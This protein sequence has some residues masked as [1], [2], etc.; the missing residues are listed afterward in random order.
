MYYFQNKNFQITIGFLLLLTISSLIFSLVL[1]DGHFAYA[2]DD[3]YIHMS[4][5]KH[6]VNQGI[7]SVDG[8]TYASASSSPLWVLVLSPFYLLLGAKLFVY[9]PF[10]LNLLFQILSLQLIF[11]ITKKYTNQ[12]LH[13]LFGIT[14]ILFTPFMALSFGGM[15][16]S[17]QIFLI[18]FCINLF[19][20]YIDAPNLLKSKIYLLIL[21]PFVVFVRYE[22]LA[23]IMGIAI[24]IL[25]YFRDWKLSLGIVA[26]SLIFIVLFGLWSKFIL[27]LGFVPSS[28]MAKSL[29]GDKRELFSLAMS[30]KKNFFHNFQHD[31]IYILFLFNLFILIQSFLLKNRQIYLLSILFIM[32]LFAHLAFA[33][34]GWLY[35]YEAYLIVFGIFNIFIFTYSVYGSN[36]KLLLALFLVLLPFFDRQVFDAPIQAIHGSKNIYEQQIQMANFLHQKCNTCEV[37]ANDIGAITYFTNIHLLDLFGLG[38]YEVIELKKRSAYTNE[39]KNNLL[40]EKNIS[41]IIIYDAWFS[42]TTIS[43]YTKIAEWK[44]LNNVVC[45]SDT[46]SFYSRND[47]IKENS[48]KI[49]DYSNNSLPKGVIVSLKGIKE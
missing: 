1:T 6:F 31:Y 9:I 7:W 26:S 10:I 17:M 19:L 14:I 30:F 49:E 16:H 2:L 39:V 15:E 5:V 11:K 29:I 41:L 38:S 18:L 45:G 46:V 42:D 24:I 47:Q 32:T 3:P 35:R 4:T 43:N 13:Y 40:K 34:L 37:A 23:L 28:I 20:S 8:E 22:N 12:E 21:A 25:F 48:I 36:P 27:N 33:S 44:I